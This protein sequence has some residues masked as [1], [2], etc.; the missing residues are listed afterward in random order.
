MTYNGDWVNDMW[1]GYGVLNQSCTVYTGNFANGKKYGQ[2]KLIWEGKQQ[3]Y[4]GEWQ[5]NTYRK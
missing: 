3:A 4:E 1:H 2:G 5:E